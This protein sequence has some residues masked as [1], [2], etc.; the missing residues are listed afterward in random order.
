MANFDINECIIER[1][2][3]FHPC[4]IDR[5]PYCV[6]LISYIAGRAMYDM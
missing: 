2:H 4:K 5:A 1:E 6:R 3:L